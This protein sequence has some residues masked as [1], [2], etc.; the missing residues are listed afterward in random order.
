MASALSDSRHELAAAAQAHLDTLIGKLKPL[1]SE[2]PQPVLAQ[3]E[4]YED[5]DG[6]DS[7]GDPTEMFHRDIGV[8]TSP[9]ISRPSSPSQEPK[10]SVAEAQAKKASNI[11][12]VLSE[13]DLTIA[14]ELHE[15]SRLQDGVDD[16]KKYLDSLMYNP[17]T[18]S[19]GAGSAFGAKRDEDDEIGRVKREI[20]AV[21]GVL[22]T[23]RSFP[24]VGAAGYPTHPTS[25]KQTRNAIGGKT[26]PPLKN[27][28]K[29]TTPLTTKLP[30]QS[31]QA[32]TAPQKKHTNSTPPRAPPPSAP[33]SPH[34]PLTVRR[35]ITAG[36]HTPV[37][38][39]I[40][41]INM[42][43]P[44]RRVPA[45]GSSALRTVLPRGMADGGDLPDDE[46]SGDHESVL[47]EE[48]SPEG[49]RGEAAA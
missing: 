24:G 43:T 23:A 10:V 47:E 14:S 25:P 35:D 37:D 46:E 8:Q 29:Q 2:V 22:L 36:N 20:R 30:P 33:R 34:S 21:K 11:G 31:P 44:R 42:P 6:E 39:D 3:G 41:D 49:G 40:N 12:A 5:N 18:F 17:P 16:L 38:F 9:A 7:D 32:P 13:V 15:T 48:V 27:K 19:Y 28:T 26:S 45:P 4:R 1:V